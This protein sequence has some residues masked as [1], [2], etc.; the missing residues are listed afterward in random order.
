MRMTHD[1]NGFNTHQKNRVSSAP[2]Y[3][4][5]PE[6]IFTGTIFVPQ[7]SDDNLGCPYERTTPRCRNKK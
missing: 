3:I 6:A 2:T 4:F 1:D 7:K 5:T